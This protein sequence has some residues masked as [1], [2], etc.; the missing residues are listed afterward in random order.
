MKGRRPEREARDQGRVENRE[1]RGQRAARRTG[2]GGAAAREPG[3]EAADKPTDSVSVGVTLSGQDDN[4]RDIGVPCMTVN[5]QRPETTHQAANDAAADTVNPTATSARP[6]EPAGTS[7]E[8]RDESHKSTG[9]YLG[10]RGEDDESRGPGARCMR[11]TAQRP[12]TANS[13]AGE[14]TADATN[15]NVTSAGPTGPAGASHKP[16]DAPQGIA[17]DDVGP[18]VREVDERTRMAKDAVDETTDDVSLAAPAGSPVNSGVA[19]PTDGITDATVNGIETPPSTP[20]EGECNAQRRAN[21]ACTGQ[22]HGAIAHGEDP[23]AWAE[24]H[25]SCTT[26]G[27]L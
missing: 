23:S 3:E 17:G 26:N 8:L 24:R 15:P 19:T 2:E 27:G 4:S 16:Q 12:Q 1:R 5:P 11:V 6:A 7:H 21:G 20:L 10:S 22:Q 14:A 25:A 9:S 18:E 13:T